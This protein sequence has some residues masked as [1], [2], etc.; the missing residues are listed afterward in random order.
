MVVN[1][2]SQPVTSGIVGSITSRKYFPAR[3]IFPG[4]AE[5]CDT[6]DNDCDTGID[7]V[8][9]DLDGFNVCDDCNDLNARVNPGGLE[10]CDTVDNNCNN[11]VDE[12]T[13]AD[14]DGEAG[15]A[16]GGTDACVGLVGRGLNSFVGYTLST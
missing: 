8:D 3:L 10:L 1:H 16:C 4:A 6:V 14:N 11:Q 15:I 13:D 2:S 7:N 5:A 12:I 9:A